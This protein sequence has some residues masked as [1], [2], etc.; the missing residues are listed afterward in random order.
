MIQNY[1]NNFQKIKNRNSSNLKKSNHNETISLTDPK[2]EENNNKNVLH[3][4][5]E[6]RNINYSIKKLSKITSNPI[7]FIKKVMF[8]TIYN[9]LVF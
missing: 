9:C 2:N 4:N 5:S 8:F 3:N 7:D 6:K 1:F